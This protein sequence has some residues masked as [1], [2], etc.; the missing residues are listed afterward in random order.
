MIG[1]FY[2]N[3]TQKT[4]KYKTLPKDNFNEEFVIISGGDVGSTQPAEDMTKNI[5][6]TKPRAIFI[7][8]IIQFKILL[9]LYSKGRCSL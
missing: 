1:V 2:E 6:S 5:V 3:I 8:L 4:M 9:N 7:G